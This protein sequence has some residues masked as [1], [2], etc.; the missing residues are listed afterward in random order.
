VIIVV[1]PVGVGNATKAKELLLCN[2][3]DDEVSDCRRPIHRILIRSR[4]E[5]AIITRPNIPPPQALATIMI[6]I[7]RMYSNVLLFLL[8][9][10]V[11]E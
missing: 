4:A 9:G 7:V 10:F 11:C 2:L 8:C 1:C 3:S 5:F 6:A